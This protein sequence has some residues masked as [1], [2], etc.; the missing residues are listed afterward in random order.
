MTQVRAPS[1]CIRD[2]GCS[3]ICYGNY[4]VGID[5]AVLI[6][7]LLR[8]W[9]GL[10]GLPRRRGRS[11]RLPLSGGLLLLLVLV[12]LARG[13]VTVLSVTMRG[14]CLHFCAAGGIV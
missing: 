1:T 9:A 12:R 13:I 7:W 5:E 3:A 4:P 8:F 11:V 14:L 2:A 10:L 6:V